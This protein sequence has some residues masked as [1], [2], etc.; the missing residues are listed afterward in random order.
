MRGGVVVVVVKIYRK[1]NMK[2]YKCVISNKIRLTSKENK[3]VVYNIIK[4]NNTTI[5]KGLSTW[6]FP[7]VVVR[8][9]FC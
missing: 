8:W 2:A 5:T 4:K 7:P 1:Y 3:W 6:S 9:V